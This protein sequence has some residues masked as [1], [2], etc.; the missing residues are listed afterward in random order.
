MS[1]VEMFTREEVELL[2]QDH[3]RIGVDYRSGQLGRIPSFPM[4]R[5]EAE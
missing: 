2:S 1:C 3:V 5:L 4:I